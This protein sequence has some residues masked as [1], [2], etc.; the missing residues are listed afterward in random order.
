MHSVH[1]TTSA[2]VASTPTSSRL[3]ERKLWGTVGTSAKIGKRTPEQRENRR[4]EREA[5]RKDKALAET[6]PVLVL[7]RGSMRCS[8]TRSETRARGATDA[9]RADAEART[10]GARLG[11]CCEVIE[12]DIRTA[13]RWL[14]HG[15]DGG[16]DRRRGPKTPP[17]N[18]L[19]QHEREQ[20]VELVTSEQFRDLPPSQI[21]PR[22]AD[23]GIYVASESSF[24]RLLKEVSLNAHRGRQRPP[25]NKRPKEHRA[26]EP[27][28]V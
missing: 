17:A 28:H 25:R 21:V 24:Y 1:D 19:S 18:K 13:Q 10:A 5:R 9:P 15:P 3:G 4:L 11:P 20:I 22:L 8:R 2:V 6:T 12:L 7:R 23:M 27:N 14:K 16:E 26:T